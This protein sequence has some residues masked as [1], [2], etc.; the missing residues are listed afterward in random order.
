MKIL[1]CYYLLIV[2][3]PAKVNIIFKIKHKRKKKK[4]K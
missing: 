2:I 1:L 4:V 3:V